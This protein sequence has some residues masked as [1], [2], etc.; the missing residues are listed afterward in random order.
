MLRFAA[1]VSIGILA[2]CFAVP[3]M[4]LHPARAGILG[5]TATQDIQANAKDSFR[6]KLNVDLVAIDAVVRNRSNAY[7][8]RLAA[9][10]FAVYD[11]GV[12]QPLSHFSQGQEPLAVALIID[13][14]PS[15]RIWLADLKQ[16]ALSA[17]DLLKP[18]DKIVLFAFDQCPTQLTD[19]TSD[20]ARIIQGIEE[21]KVGPQTNYYEAVLTAARLLKYKAPDYRRAILVISD[22]YSS[23]FRTKEQEV[24]RELQDAAITLVGIKTPGE[25]KGADVSPGDIEKLVIET[26]GEVLALDEERMMVAALEDA[27]SNLKNRYHLVIAPSNRESDTSFHRLELKIKPEQSCSDCRVLARKGYYAGSRRPEAGNGDARGITSYPSCSGRLPEAYLKATM[28][29]AAR[30][31]EETGNILFEAHTNQTKTV[32]EGQQI[33]LDLQV[34]PAA[35][36]FRRIDDQYTAGLRLLFQWNDARKIPGEQWESIDLRLDQEAYDKLLRSKIPYSL[37]IHS[38]TSLQSIRAVVFDPGANEF[39]LRI[40]KIAAAPLPKAPTSGPPLADPAHI[41]EVPQPATPQL[42]QTRI[43]IIKMDVRQ[44]LVPVVVTDAKGHTVQSLEKGDFRILEDGEEQQIIAVS[45]EADGADRLFA[46]TLSSEGQISLPLKGTP[47]PAGKLPN[48]VC[49]IVVDALNSEF[50]SFAAVRGALKKMFREEKSGNMIYGLVTLGQE[51]KVI[52]PWTTDSSSLMRTVDNKAFG[53][54]ILQGEQSNLAVQEEHLVRMLQNYCEKNPCPSKTGPSPR[55]MDLMAIRSFAATSSE[56]RLAKMRVYFRQLRGLVESLGE[57]P[58]KRMMVLLSDGFAIQP[59][60][61]LFELIGMYVGTSKVFMS[62]VPALG[63]EMREVLRAAQQRDTAFYTIDSRGLYVSPT[64]DDV[65]VAEVR[66]M[67]NTLPNL[68]Q[69]Q[70]QKETLAAQKSDGLRELASQTGGLFF[71][72]NNDIFA[73]LRRAVEDGRAYYLLSYVPSNTAADGKFRK[74]QVEVRGKQ[75]TVR[76]KPGYWAPA[77]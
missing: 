75:L 38:K 76:S 62:P 18:E 67:R 64:S 39:G 3:S 17:L 60:R 45:T 49:L 44:V 56:L 51:L 19:L 4:N 21:V 16:A 30:L 22:N 40:L 2:I 70:Q 65:S 7:V 59:G 48:R 27:I 71:E 68:P 63:A 23:R 74:I 66:S 61:D 47:A 53:K 12:R 20:H 10:N 34:E 9:Q 15:V 14:S 46:P 29:A 26:G 72:N 24:I 37:T 54:A 36:R 50:G 31:G 1:Q 77:K 42:E 69:R 33:Q 41:P 28:S 55:D 35:V 5:K 52:H 13:C 43:P 25:N 11:N 32:A 57:M 58:G 8:G 73:G 6:I